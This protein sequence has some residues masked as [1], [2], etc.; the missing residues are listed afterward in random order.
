V[1]ESASYPD[2]DTGQSR[3]LDAYGLSA[4]CM[5][6][7]TMDF[8]FAVLLVEGINNPQPLAL[9]SKGVDVPVIYRDDLHVAGLPA[10]VPQPKGRR[11]VSIL[12][13][14][15]LES[16]HHYC[17]GAY[18]TQF[19]SFQQKKSTS[20]W[21]AWHDDAHFE[22]IRKLGDAMLFFRDSTIRGWRPGGIEAINLEFYYPVLVLQGD[23]LD[24]RRTTRGLK[25][26]PITHGR[27]RRAA[28]HGG[29]TI[30][31][32]ID[33]VVESYLPELLRT[34]AREGRRI[35]RYIQAHQAR[36]RRAC[37]L[38]AQRAKRIRGADRL[39]RAVRD[40]DSTR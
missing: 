11:W 38:I 19:C 2:P 34:I 26:R 13:A 23:L 30:S 21:M 8:A 10:V 3:E 14:L 29:E 28:I 5:L 24:V 9:L 6:N 39:A 7:E 35:E 37:R 27:L 31:Y 20:E 18:A 4:V 17:R 32:Q 1:E 15:Q 25:I 33:V 36:L 12:E 40:L 22:S 16:F